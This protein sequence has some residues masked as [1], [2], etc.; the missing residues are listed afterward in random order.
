[1]V[2]V[3]AV[4][5]VGVDTKYSTDRKVIHHEN[6]CVGGIMCTT[7][8]PEEEKFVL[9]LGGSPFLRCDDKI[10]VSSFDL[11]LFWRKEGKISP[12]L[13]VPRLDEQNSFPEPVEM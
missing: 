1:M 8:L 9:Y 6:I 7:V 10:I 3:V 2:A 12:V 11:I 13:F 5:D 4:V